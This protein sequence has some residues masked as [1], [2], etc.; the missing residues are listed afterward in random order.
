MRIKIINQSTKLM[1]ITPAPEKLIEA[2]GRTCYQSQNKIT[3]TSHTTFIQKIINNK[4]LAMIEHANAT[5]K[6]ITDRGIS[7]EIVRHRIASFAQES[8]RYVKYNSI[9]VIMPPH[10]NPAD[11]TFNA[12]HRS[13]TVAAH[14]YNQLIQQGIKPQI[15]R[16]VLPTC[17]KTELIMTANLREWLHFID[18][19][20][21][22]SAHPQIRDIANQINNTLSGYAPNIFNKGV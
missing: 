20:T 12:W 16:S 14:S 6:I 5:Y 8:T 18:L 2:I 3:D 17:L 15:A 19:R 21:H 13:I 9:T 7:H 10:I 4:H 11:D 22:K 1:H